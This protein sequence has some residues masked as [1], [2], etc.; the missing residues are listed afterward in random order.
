MVAKKSPPP[1]KPKPEK[2]KLDKPKIEKPKPEKAKAPQKLLALPPPRAVAEKLRSKTRLRPKPDVSRN[3]SLTRGLRTKLIVAVAL[4]GVVIAFHDRISRILSVPGAAGI[5]TGA[6]STIA[7]NADPALTQ[8]AEIKA[9]DGPVEGLSLSGDGRLIV[10]TS[11]QPELKLW[12]FDTHDAKGTI[13]LDDG[14]ATSLMVRNNRAITGHANGAVAVYDLD[15]KQR[16]YRFKRNDARI[17]AAAFTGSEDRVAT[18][19]H[20]WTV[21]LW[22]RSS[23]SQPAT[24][25]EGHESAVQALAVDHSGHWLA[26]GSADRTIR[27]WDLYTRET[28]R[29]YRN[30]SDF[31]SALTFSPDDTTLAAGSLDGTIK[32]LSVNSYRVQRTLNGHYTRITALA[33]SNYEDLLASASEDG[34][35]R[36]RSLKRPHSFWSLNGIGSG[37]KVLTFT[38]D[39]RTLVTGGQDGVIRLW[40]LPDPRIAQGN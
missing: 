5:T 28:R 1:D 7:A 35:V 27:L 9:Y 39:G 25:L 3:R 34:V 4:A 40:S 10:T 30:S 31:L 15:S 24:L 8:T 16:L 6:I 38:N 18:A 13:A 14:P 19:S 37:A 36:L 12:S 26:S 33:F 23:E 21:A 2:L 22:E 20:D 29:I 32:L 17:W 11:L